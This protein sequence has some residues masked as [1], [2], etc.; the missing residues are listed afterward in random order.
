VVIACEDGICGV[1]EACAR[2]DGVDAVITDAHMPGMTG[3]ELVFR[4]RALRP[5]IPV[6]MVSGSVEAEMNPLPDDA[7][8]V[9]LSKPVS[10]DRLRRELRRL[11]SRHVASG[12][13]RASLR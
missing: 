7:A 6:I 1:K 2:I 13:S 5:E 9:R 10:P 12:V 8:T 4:I 3:S 11:L